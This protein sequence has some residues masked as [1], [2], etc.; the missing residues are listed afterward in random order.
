MSGASAE[1]LRSAL[2]RITAQRGHLVAY[3]RRTRKAIE[4]FAPAALGGSRMAQAQ[5]Q[6]MA[7]V[8]G[9]ESAADIIMQR[10]ESCLEDKA[11]ETPESYRA[12]VSEACI[13]II[14]AC[15]FQDLTGQRI[16]KVSTMLVTIEKRLAGLEAALGERFGGETEDMA[17]DLVDDVLLQGPPL[18]NGGIT[19]T[20]VDAILGRKASA[21]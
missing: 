12:R 19:Q 20:D 1:E 6:M 11:G 16:T 5:Q 4:E 21:A 8:A 3:I 15:A 14:E 17:L 13:E 18:P 2:D 7:V 10:A 9:T